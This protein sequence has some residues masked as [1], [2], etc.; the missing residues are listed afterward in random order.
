VLIEAGRVVDAFDPFSRRTGDEALAGLPDEAECTIQSLAA[1]LPPAVLPLLSSLL[2]PARVRQS[3]LDSAFVNLPALAQK[4]TDERFSGLIRMRRGESQAFVLLAGGATPVTIFTE[5]WDECPVERPWQE[6][7]GGVGVQATVEE[8]NPASLLFTWRREFPSAAVTVPA[9]PGAV[10]QSAAEPRDG[11][12]AIGGDPA[13]RLLRFLLQDLPAWLRERG[14]AERWKYLVEWLGDVRAAL[15]HH[16]LE[17]PD[18]S[19]RDAFDLVT[20]DARGKVLHLTHH[21]TRV[22]RQDLADF[23][24]RVTAAKKARLKG[25][26]VGAAVLVAAS[27]DPAAI[28]AY[29]RNELGE[30]SGGWGIEEALTRY[31]G[32]VRIGP[33]RGFH[34][35]LLTDTGTGFDPILPG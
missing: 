9:G 24:A 18:G 20:F 15:L 6:W 8:V 22:T 2:R 25:G 21:E 10:P 29:R 3:G 1:D 34:L 23:V 11:G 4:L 28:T 32:F 13:W 19:A 7:I 26:D 35:L 12:P 27:F 17:R 30:A 31:E 14:R 5:G 16:G 33:R